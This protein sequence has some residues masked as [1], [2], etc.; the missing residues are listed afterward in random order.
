MSGGLITTN[1]K[2][3]L[4]HRGY[5]ASPTIT[6]PTKF[7]I[8]TAT[9]AA[10][11]GDTDLGSAVVISGTAYVKVFE[12]GYPAFDYTAMTGT[13][14]T[15]LTTLEANGNALTEIGIFNTDG[16]AL[17]ESRDLFTAISK[18]TSDELIFEIVTTVL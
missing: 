2:K 1:G 17:M 4:L 14:R 8:G 15:R 3:I 6:A 7:K 12:S 5:T 13:I 9:V 16:T 18:T 11:V 10:T